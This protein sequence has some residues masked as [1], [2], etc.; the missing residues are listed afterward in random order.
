MSDLQDYLNDP[1]RDALVAQVR[2]KIDELGVDA[3]YYQYVSITGRIM[4]KTIPSKHWE[5]HVFHPMH[6]NCWPCPI[7]IRFASYPGT[8]VWRGC[9]AR[10]SSAV[11]TR[12]GPKNFSIPIH[13]AISDAFTSS[14]RMTMA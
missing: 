2:K 4:G 5:R 7:Q 14:S 13:A 11:K 3:I 6:L 9:F 8:S 1:A 12:L 10:F